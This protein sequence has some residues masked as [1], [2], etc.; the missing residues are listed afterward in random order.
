MHAG[1]VPHLQLPAVQLSASVALHA[2]QAV[3][4]APQAAI[5]GVLHVDPEQQPD[6][7]V[8]E[9]AVQTPA[10][11]EPVPHETQAVPAEP[12]GPARAASCSHHRAVAPHH[13]GW[14]YF[15]GSKSK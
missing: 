15:V 4:P 3:P 6:V 10:L 2:V 13:Q 8:T 7:H 5:R 9:Q 14:P 11:H 1:P 12:H